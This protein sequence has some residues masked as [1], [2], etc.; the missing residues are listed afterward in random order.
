VV[1]KLSKIMTET[2][3]HNQGK[4]RF[5]AVSPLRLGKSV[6][7]GVESAQA[8]RMRFAGAGSDHRPSG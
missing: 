1:E 7:N 4:C 3:R 8:E 5:I 6:K 2:S